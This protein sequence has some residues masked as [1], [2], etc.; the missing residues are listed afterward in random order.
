MEED[1][2]QSIL[3]GQMRLD[4][5]SET[6]DA[7]RQPSSDSTE[8]RCE[9]GGAMQRWTKLDVMETRCGPERGCVN[10]EQH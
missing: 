8:S 2:S 7:Y 9:I 3:R 1:I 4:R 10:G 5:I 6:T